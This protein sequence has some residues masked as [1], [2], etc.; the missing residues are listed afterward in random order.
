MHG[1]RPRRGHGVAGA[2]IAQGEAANSIGT[3]EEG[4]GGVVGAGGAARSQR[5]LASPSSTAVTCGRELTPE[6]NPLS[7]PSYSK[8][9]AIVSQ[10]LDL[11]LAVWEESLEK[12]LRKLPAPQNRVEGG[13]LGDQTQ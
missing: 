12:V 6:R 7:P 8:A 2:R 1:H 13:E 5:L 11:S 3:S 10:R 9:P 4:R